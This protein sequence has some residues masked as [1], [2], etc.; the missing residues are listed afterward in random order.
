[1]AR[2]SVRSWIASLARNDGW[3]GSIGSDACRA[4]KP[5]DGEPHMDGCASVGS[6]LDCFA[7]ARN[8][9]GKRGASGAACFATE[10]RGV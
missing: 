3:A 7:R 8:D 9:G 6:K 1:M 4:C 10:A 5:A 2:Q